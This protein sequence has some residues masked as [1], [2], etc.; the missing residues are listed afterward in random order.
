MASSQ[1]AISCPNCNHAWFREERQVQLDPSV[2]IRPDLPL[3]AQTL[4]EQFQYV[5]LNCNQVL[6]HE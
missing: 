4:A 3:A 2:V 1:H 6:H 5:C